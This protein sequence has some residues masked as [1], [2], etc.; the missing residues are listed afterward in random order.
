MA[1]AVLNLFE[2]NGSNGFVIT[3]IPGINRY[4]FSSGISV[5]NAGDINGDGIDD[6]IIGARYASPN[7]Q[8]GAGSSYVVFGNSSG[9]AASFNLSSLNGSNGFVINGIDFDENSGSSVSSAGDINGDGIDDLIIGARFADPNG[10]NV[11]GSSYVVF[12]SKGFTT[13][14]R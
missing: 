10:Q 5:S 7:S 1:N 12:G 11:A 3:D 13:S 6:L 8:N 4:S 2:L 14:Y 9:F